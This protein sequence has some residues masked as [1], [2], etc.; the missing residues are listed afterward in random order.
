MNIKVKITHILILYR[1]LNFVKN[2]MKL[3]TDE[4]KKLGRA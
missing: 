3:M 2:C 4:R 1:D